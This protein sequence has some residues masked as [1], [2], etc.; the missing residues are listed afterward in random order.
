MS[1]FR[2]FP[3]FRRLPSKRFVERHQKTYILPT[4]YGV[5]FGV[6]CILLLAIAFASTNNAVYFLCFLLSVLGVQSLVTTNRNT[7][8]LDITR[9]EVED[10]FADEV[11]FARLHLQNASAD[12]LYE[13]TIET[14]PISKVFLSVLRAKERKELQ[15]PI[16]IHQAGIHAFPPLK[17]SSDFPF[18]FAR[19]W[20]KHYGELNFGVFPARRGESNF[21]AV[22]FADTHQQIFN[23]EEFKSHRDYEVSDSPRRIDWKV[24][25]RLDKIMVKEYD[26]PT[27]TKVSLRLE[28]C[29]QITIDEKKSQ[30]SLWID[31]AE[32]KNFEYALMLP[33]LNLAF[34]KGPQ[35][36][37]AC[38]RALL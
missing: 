3:F 34:G 38:L 12:D 1:F 9:M 26:Q 6:V 7:E 2:K 5:A 15:L 24:T 20:K 31:L 25:A 13:L 14:S 17:V 37:L 19:S 29:P 33:K 10:F 11:G 28:D 8:R 4:L 22:A 16:V 18:H 27:N 30:L 35:H 36:R 23:Q 21:P 32:K